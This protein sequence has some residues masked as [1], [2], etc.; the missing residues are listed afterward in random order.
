LVRVITTGFVSLS[1]L[2]ITS[3]F[4]LP[5]HESIIDACPK[6]NTFNILFDFCV[7][8]YSKIFS[9]SFTVIFS[10]IIFEIAFAIF[11]EMMGKTY[12]D[13]KSIQL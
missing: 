6:I 10:C 9:A 7:N 2:L 5:S 13:P 4:P 3:I 12:K 1:Y 8:S 11:V